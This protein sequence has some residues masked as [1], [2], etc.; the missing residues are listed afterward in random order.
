MNTQRLAALRISPLH[1]QQSLF[2]SLA[3]LITLIIVQQFAHWTQK[4]DVAPHSTLSV[5]SAPFAK[6]SALKAT[7]VGLSFQSVEGTAASVDQAPRQQSWV[8]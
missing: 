5:H 6:A 7:D 4:Q 1:I 8:F 3:L 2:A